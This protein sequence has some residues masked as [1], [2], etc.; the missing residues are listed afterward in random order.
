ME[1][2]I[3]LRNNTSTLDPTGSW[4]TDQTHEFRPNN[5]TIRMRGRTTHGGL[6]LYIQALYTSGMSTGYD[7]PVG[8]RGTFSGAA[9]YR[10]VNN[11]G[12]MNSNSFDIGSE[13]S[14]FD[15]TSDAMDTVREI[16]WRASLY[17]PAEN[18]EVQGN[19]SR[20]QNLTRTEWDAAYLQRIEVQQATKQVVYRS[21]YVFLAF[22]VTMTVS[23]MACVLGLSFGWW[24]LGREVSLSPIEIAKAFAAPSLQ[25][26]NSNVSVSTILKELGGER[27]SYGASWD[28]GTSHGGSVPILRF[29]PAGSCDKPRKGQVLA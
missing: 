1:Y 11:V 18:L 6:W 16:S 29:D 25:I 21:Q 3:V 17:I 5:G 20:P 22:A 14:F 26:A 2:P 27:L 23:T 19:R 7:G 13:L 12:F 8:W 24:H 28:S 15:P 10:Y 9:A 4:K